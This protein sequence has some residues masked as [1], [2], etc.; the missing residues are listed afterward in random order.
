MLLIIS[1]FLTC[2]VITAMITD[3]TSFIIPNMLV[4]IILLTY[5]TVVFL[6][7]V[8]PDWKMSLLIGGATFAI[9]FILFAFKAMGGGDVKLLAV[10]AMFVGKAVFF[11]FLMLMAVLGGAL[12]IVLLL[13]RPIAAY[14]F[15]RLGKPST[16]IPRILTVGEPVPYGVAIGSAFLIM[17]WNG[18]IS[19]ITL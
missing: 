16:S 6:A 7:P 11:Q 17:L 9:G 2:M 3:I 19:G 10:I 5:P 13:S 12:S 18:Q 1:V 8:M 15:A 4:V 14:I